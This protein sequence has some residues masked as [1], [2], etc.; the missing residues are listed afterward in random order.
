MRLTRPNSLSLSLSLSL[1]SPSQWRGNLSIQRDRSIY[2][3]E[4]TSENELTF[5]YQNS[6]KLF[7]FQSPLFLLKTHITIERLS[8]EVYL[9]IL[10]VFQFPE[11]SWGLH[12]LDISP[13]PCGGRACFFLFPKQSLRLWDC[14]PIFGD[15]LC[16]FWKQRTVR[17]CT[18]FMPRCVSTA[19]EFTQ[20]N[21]NG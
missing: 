6:G 12:L 21:V 11:L 20:P 13:W 8:R 10:S 4:R 14:K 7:P 15:F 17:G 19:V 1:S 16:G 5:R 18:H 3:A 2:C 9:S